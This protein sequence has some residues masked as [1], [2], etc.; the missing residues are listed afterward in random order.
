MVHDVLCCDHFNEV[1]VLTEVIS[2]LQDMMQT[3]T[4]VSKNQTIVKVGKIRNNIKA[5]SRD[6]LL[7][8]K[9]KETN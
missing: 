9:L 3:V 2:T 6:V 1:S 8:F 4:K 7:M 5:F